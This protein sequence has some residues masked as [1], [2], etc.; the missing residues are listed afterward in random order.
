MSG[1]NLCI[2]IPVY[3]R[4]ATVGRAIASLKYAGPDP[5]EVVVVDDGSGD[6]SAEAARAALALNPDLRGRVI[7]Q[8]NAGPG[9]AR[10]TG[11][12]ATD[13]RYLAFLDS[14]DYW[15]P[16]ALDALVEAVC[17]AEAPALIFLK[18]VDAADGETPATGPGPVT[19]RNHPGFLEA[20]ERD[21]GTRYGS[22]NVVVR[23]DV[24]AGLGGYATDIRCSEDTDLFLRAAAAG[25]CLVLGGRPLVVH[26]VGR[27]DSLTSN[28][29]SVLEGFERMLRAEGEGRYPCLPG[30]SVAKARFLGKCAAHTIREAFG[31]GHPAEGYRLLWRHAGLLVRAQSWH[32]LMRLPIFPLLS[33]IRP[34]SYPMRWAAGRD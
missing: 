22:C 13:A 5:V 10:N 6:D 34:Q 1:A 2:I 31:A 19:A 27:G 14:D 8:T 18:T 32:W 25:R 30:A 12:A 23:A 3:N 28:F 7:T 24:F 20:V 29:P 26:H 21:P 9:A 15:L 11:A 17:T 4:A 16:G 33:L